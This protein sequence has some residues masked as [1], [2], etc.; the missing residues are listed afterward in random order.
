MSRLLTPKSRIIPLGATGLEGATPAAPGPVSVTQVIIVTL[1]V[2]AIASGAYFIFIPVFLRL[3]DQQSLL[4]LQTGRLGVG[5]AT[6]DDLANILNQTL[7]DVSDL[8]QQI[9]DLL[10]ADTQMQI[11]DMQQQAQI[12]SLLQ[13]EGSMMTTEE[14]VLVPVANCGIEAFFCPG[15]GGTVNGRILAISTGNVM[16][17]IF[18][19]DNVTTSGVATFASGTTSEFFIYCS[20]DTMTYGTAWASVLP[21]NPPSFLDGTKLQLLT[22]DL[23]NSLQTPLYPNRKFRFDT[24]IM[25]DHYSIYYPSTF[26]YV[27]IQSF[28]YQDSNLTP[29]PT[30]SEVTYDGPLRF[31]LATTS[32]VPVIQFLRRKRGNAELPTRARLSKPIEMERRRPLPRR[33]RQWKSKQ[34]M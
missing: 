2:T 31:P 19:V 29:L 9:D 33:L 17:I 5:N 10:L 34:H 32:S 4:N 12:N 6:L 7:S 16:Q 3:D 26:N 23:A 27:I 24:D 25:L 14:T 15:A 18:E 1:I 22:P 11:A 28:I 21:L 30:C 20:I 13:N 8:R